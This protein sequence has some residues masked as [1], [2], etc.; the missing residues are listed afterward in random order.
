V[1][2]LRNQKKRFRPGETEDCTFV[3]ITSLLVLPQ[4]EAASKLGIS[5]SMLCKRFKE[6][7]RRKWPYRY[8]RKIDKMIR[9]MTVN[10]DVSILTGEEKS[11]IE[12]LTLER[13]QC[14]EPVRIR[15]TGK[16]VIGFGNVAPSL[17]SSQESCGTSSDLDD[18]LSNEEAEE[19]EGENPNF[20]DSLEETDDEE[21]AI[22]ALS[23]NQLRQAFLEGK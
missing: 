5:E 22:V 8:L 16:D 21:L 18:D 6:C 11:K 10:K 1:I 13:K 4:K 14:L 19:R 12:R 20:G 17:N 15:I 23:L 9:V 7:T 2:H 3:D